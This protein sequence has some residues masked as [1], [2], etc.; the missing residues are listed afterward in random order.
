MRHFLWCYAMQNMIYLH[1][2]VRK[3]CEAG[4]D[5]SSDGDKGIDRV[6]VHV[7]VCVDVVL[8]NQGEDRYCR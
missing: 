5:K 8:S 7:G 6:H 4:S 2:L 3:A 1:P